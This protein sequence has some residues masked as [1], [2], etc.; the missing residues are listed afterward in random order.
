MISKQIHK[1]R[2]ALKHAGALEDR[3]QLR[4]WIITELRDDLEVL[5]ERKAAI[6]EDFRKRLEKWQTKAVPDSVPVMENPANARDRKLYRLTGWIALISEMALAAW[7]FARLQ[8]AFWIG[9][10]TALGITFTLHGIFLYLFED[11]DRPKATMHRIKVYAALSAIIGF[12]VAVAGGALARYV[13]GHLAYLL[14]PFFS[15]SLWLGTLS[16]MVLAASLFTIAHLKGWAVCHEQEH[17]QADGEERAT[18]AFL[19]E[20]GKDVERD[21]DNP[22]VQLEPKRP[23]LIPSETSKVHTLGAIIALAILS[24]RS[25]YYPAG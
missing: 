13:T 24:S 18:R 22:A 9:A 21:S 7:I 5:R 16:L 20:L 8:V 2:L 23:E 6:K 14:L 17:A 25:S 3:D 10:L 1:A 19:Q 11:E 15:F 4:D 12:L